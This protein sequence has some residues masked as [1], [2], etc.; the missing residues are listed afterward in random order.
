MFKLLSLCAG[1]ALA[2][3]AVTY[4]SASDSSRM[5][6]GGD[7]DRRI[8]HSIEQTSSRIPW[9][10]VCKSAREWDEDS[11]KTRDDIE[12]AER[13]VNHPTFDP[14]PADRKPGCCS[15]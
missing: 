11:Q 12:K 6:K 1:L 7:P 3:P 4:A 14:S 8:C 5:S 13:Y 2:F 9:R 15:S 10:K